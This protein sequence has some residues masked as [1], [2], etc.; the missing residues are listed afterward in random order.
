MKKILGMEKQTCVP[1]AFILAFF[2]G[3]VGHNLAYALGVAFGENLFFTILEVGLFLLATI[4]APLGFLGSLIYNTYT[5]ITKKQPADIWKLGFLGIFG[6]ITILIFGF[7]LENKFMA[8]L[9]ILFL[10]P[11]LFFLTLLFKRKSF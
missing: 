10:I 6:I 4:I 1:Y 3:F 7:N 8:F 11:F 5:Y 9:T 2:I